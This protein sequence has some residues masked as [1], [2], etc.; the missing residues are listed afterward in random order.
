[1]LIFVDLVFIL[2]DFIDE[3]FEVIGIGVNLE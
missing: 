1:M 3:L 2:V